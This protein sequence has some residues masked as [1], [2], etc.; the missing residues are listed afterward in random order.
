MV[1]PDEP[2]LGMKA[3]TSRSKPHAGHVLFTAP[4]LTPE[5]GALQ[6]GKAG[7]GPWKRK[8]PQGAPQAKSTD[9]LA[10]QGTAEPEGRAPGMCFPRL[11]RALD[12]AAR[13]SAEHR[14]APFPTQPPSSRRRPGRPPAAAE[15]S[16]PSFPTPGR[17]HPPSPP[18][19]ARRN[20]FVTA[21][22]LGRRGGGL[23]APAE[24]AGGR[25]RPAR[26][27]T[28]RPRGTRRP[29]RA[30]ASDLSPNPFR[31]SARNH[32]LPSPGKCGT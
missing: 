1:C 10:V 19:G 28:P 31:S 30:P 24:N 15:P 7:E 8:T 12:R 2:L 29:R 27:L 21:R 18:K 16:P 11:H 26:R 14:R 4:V 32:P 9:T 6:A 25:P 23:R 17:C 5:R 20:P 13:G 3:H 22:S